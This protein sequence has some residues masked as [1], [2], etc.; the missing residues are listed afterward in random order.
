MK[1]MRAPVRPQPTRSWGLFEP[2]RERTFGVIWSSS[3]L[4]NFGQLILGVGAAW[5]MTR[6][7]S[8]AEMVALV[9]T[10]LMLPLMLVSVLAGAAA[11]MFDRRKVA[12]AGLGFAMLCAASLTTLAVLGLT[13]PWLLLASCSFIGAG[14]AL[15]GPAWQASVREQVQPEHLPAA[16]AL[17]SI[18]YNVARSFG[19]ALGGAIVLLAGAKAAFAVN[20]ICYVP[21]FTAFYLWRREPAPARL[22]PERM[23]R[24]IVSGAR[25]V[26]HSPPIR[27]VLF[28]ALVYG[29]TTGSV[30]AL[31]PIVA[32]DLL[33]GGAGTYGLLLGVYGVGAVAGALL[34]GRLR[35]RFEA[36]HLVSVFAIVCGLMVLVIGLSR[37]TLLTAAAMTVAGG[38]W[39]LLATMLNLGVQFSAPR[40]VTARALSWY[41]S[42]LTGGLAFG[43][44]IWGSLASQFGV[45]HAL[46]LS[47]GSL[48]LT[49]LIG[50]VLPIPSVSEGESE[51]VE[52]GREPEVALALTLRSGP[53]V[54]EIDYEVEPD[55]ARQF[56]DTMLKLQRAR[57]RNGAFDWSLARDIAD[58]AVWTERYLCP[59]WGD[60]LRLRSRLTRSDRDLQEMADSFHRAEGGTRVRRRLER[61]FGSVRWRADTPDP[62][63]EPIVTFGP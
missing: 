8:S 20:A 24:A 59:T 58:P 49:P 60:Y 17:G 45:A 10:A 43:A 25:Y 21:L 27:A 46:L 52:F 19:P 30:A 36:E 34:I 22:P 56:Y 12:L 29:L 54:I 44:W 28:R 50:F 5:E 7:V 31:T 1:V 37:S 32:R 6:L 39:M 26:M 14:V 38:A 57:Q 41:M 51:P 18:S 35:L 15:Y 23:D 61:P 4:S 48:L 47:G 40:W 2:L 33:H 11:D 53:V 9:Q 16:V 55:Q 42:A 3:V 62:R 13:T 63:N